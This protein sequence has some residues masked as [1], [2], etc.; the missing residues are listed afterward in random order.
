MHA[1]RALVALKDRGESSED[2]SEDDDDSQDASRF[3][4]PVKRAKKKEPESGLTSFIVLR[5]RPL[6]VF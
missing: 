4:A 2:S 3:K 5:H 6:I 1:Q